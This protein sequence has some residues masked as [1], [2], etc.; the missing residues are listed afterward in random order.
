MYIAYTQQQANK[1]HSS[2]MFGQLRDFTARRQGGH[3]GRCMPDI[4]AESPRQSSNVIH[5]VT[6]TTNMRTRIYIVNH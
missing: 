6:V 3:T 2:I 4:L 1:T 5:P